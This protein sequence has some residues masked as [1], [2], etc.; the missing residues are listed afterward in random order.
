MMNASE[1]E[2][3]RVTR[4]TTM[5]PLALIAAT[6][7]LLGFMGCVA[8]TTETANTTT[9]VKTVER[10][11]CEQAVK[12]QLRD[13]DSYQRIQFAGGQDWAMLHFRARNGFGGYDD[14]HARCD[15]RN[16]YVTADLNPGREAAAES[17]REEVEQMQRD[18]QA[19]AVA[20]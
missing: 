3:P 16:G 12:A 18:A 2:H 7:G 10:Y 20:F 14:G 13:P 6:L 17:I 5:R 19:A 1:G 11:A 4:V 8:T 15:Q 9:P